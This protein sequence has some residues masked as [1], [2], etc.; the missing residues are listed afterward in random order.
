[1]STIDFIILLLKIIFYLWLFAM[2]CYVVTRLVAVAWHKTRNEFQR[3][4][5]YYD[6]QQRDDL[7]YEKEEKLNGYEDTL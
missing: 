3:D 6:G 5:V 1:M 2:G 4:D 7:I